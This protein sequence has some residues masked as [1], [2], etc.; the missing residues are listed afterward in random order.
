MWKKIT[1]FNKIQTIIDMNIS[2]LKSI[3]L[4]DDDEI[5]NLFNKIFITKLNLNINADI[6][7]NGKEALDFL[8]KQCDFEDENFKLEPCL[9]LLDIKMPIMNGWEFLETYSENFP[10][11]IRNQIVIVMLTTSEDEGDM[12]KALENPNVKEFI[13]KPLSEEVFKQ[14]IDKHFTETVSMPNFNLS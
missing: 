12:I 4:I 13:R 1:T 9:L 2:F 8:Y 7:L 11:H 6:L 10:E 14:L 5:S 3:V